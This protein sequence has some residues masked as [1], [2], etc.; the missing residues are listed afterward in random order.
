VGELVWVW[1]WVGVYVCVC[2]RDFVYLCFFV[3]VR[4]WVCEPTGLL[5]K[6][7]RV[8]ARTCASVGGW[9]GKLVG[10]LVGGWI[11]EWM[12]LCTGVYDVYACMFALAVIYVSLCLL[13]RV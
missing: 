13:M 3:F 8:R 11:G 7:V 4:V 6:V 2:A 5:L 9:V 1:V 12:C 10:G